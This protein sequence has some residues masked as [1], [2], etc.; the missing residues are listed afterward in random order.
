L[1]VENTQKPHEKAFL[2]LGNS[3]ERRFVTVKFVT[4]LTLGMSIG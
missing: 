2:D 3:Y 1:T 4:G